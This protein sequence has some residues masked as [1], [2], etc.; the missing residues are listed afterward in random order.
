MR[1]HPAIAVLV[2]ADRALPVR[3]PRDHTRMKLI[4][5]ALLLSVIGLG[6]CAVLMLARL[7]LPLPI[8]VVHILA[9]FLLFFALGK[10]AVAGQ[11][12]AQVRL[13]PAGGVDPR[14]AFSNET[15][16]RLWLGFKFLAAATALTMALLLIRRGPDALNRYFDKAPIAP[17]TSPAPAAPAASTAP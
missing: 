16:F 3:A 8:A 13:V 9:G 17:T 1:L 6:A 4:R 7:I 15:L 10:A 12:I 14:L 5:F 11:A 2:A